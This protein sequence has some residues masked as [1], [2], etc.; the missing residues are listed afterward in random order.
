MSAAGGRMPG[1]AAVRAPRGWLDL[2]ARHP[3]L[4][5]A[6]LPTVAVPD[7]AMIREPANVHREV[8]DGFRW[9]SDAA[10]F[11]VGD[12]WELPERALGV[13][14]GDC[15]D[16]CLECRRRLVERGWPQ[17]ALRLCLC[18]VPAADVASRSSPRGH[19]VLTVDLPRDTL[20]LDCLRT[21][22]MG[23]REYGWDLAS[24]SLAP[25]HGR[26]LSR[27]LPGSDRWEA[28]GQVD[29]RTAES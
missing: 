7:D 15:E 4:R 21:R 18:V 10:R 5:S 19:M 9:V 8:L 14:R 28:V 16:F 24:D 6:R 25:A 12:R 11:G 3:E 2:V 20:V 27:E 1:G 22:V 23:W 29:T 17:E 26:W 13:I